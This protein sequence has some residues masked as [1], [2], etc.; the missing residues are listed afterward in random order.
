M[1]VD[2]NEEPHSDAD[3]GDGGF[4]VSIEFIIPYGDV[5]VVLEEAE[6]ALDEISLLV[7]VAI[8]AGG[9]ARPRATG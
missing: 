2:S 1:G 8:V 6:R 3:E 7:E 4:E 9:S 5:P